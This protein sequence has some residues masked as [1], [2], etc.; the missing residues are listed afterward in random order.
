MAVEICLLPLPSTI[1][2]SGSDIRWLIIK[3]GSWWPWSGYCLEAVLHL[4][5]ALAVSSNSIHASR[6]AKGE[7]VSLHVVVYPERR[8]P[9]YADMVNVSRFG[10]NSGK[11]PDSV[12][13]RNVSASR[14]MIRLLRSG[15]VSDMF[16]WRVVVHD[17]SMCFQMEVPTMPKETVLGHRA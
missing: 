2:T 11:P 5:A 13:D 12:A 8:A 6:K 7:V 4:T 14:A 3:R 10:N 15:Q 9:V 1:K 16:R 17:F